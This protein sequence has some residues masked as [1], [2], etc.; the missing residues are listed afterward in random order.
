VTVQACSLFYRPRLLEATGTAAA[1]LHLLLRS[2]QAR[3]D[4][5]IPGVP[6]DGRSGYDLVIWLTV[7]SFQS[8]AALVDNAGGAAY[9]LLYIDIGLS[10][11]R[12]VMSRQPPRR[13]ENP[14]KRTRYAGPTS[15]LRCDA[16]FESWDRR[17]N[18]LCASCRQVIEAQPS[19]EPSYALSRSRHLPRS[20]DDR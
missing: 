1:G 2:D 4:V 10:P 20:P 13:R 5:A 9:W 16:V 18:R 7:C 19:D 12:T 6:L 11:L 8:S 3:G 15:C 14:P 17:Q